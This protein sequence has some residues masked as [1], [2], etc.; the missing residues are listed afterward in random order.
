[1]NNWQSTQ[2]RQAVC[3]DLSAGMSVEEVAV[4]HGVC[5]AYVYRIGKNGARKT[6]VHSPAVAARLAARD[7]EIVRL[8]AL[9]VPRGRIMAAVGCSLGTLKARRTALGIRK[10]RGLQSKVVRQAA[11]L[12]TIN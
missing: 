10:P 11:A 8:S 1:M 4:K 9:D 7:E 6:T 2:R 3:A 5:S 12:M